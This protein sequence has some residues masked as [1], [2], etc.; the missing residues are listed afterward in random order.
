MYP[1]CI[2][3]HYKDRLSTSHCFPQIVPFGSMVQRCQGF[4]WWLSRINMFAILCLVMLSGAAFIPNSALSNQVCVAFLYIHLIWNKSETNAWKWKHVVICL[5]KPFT[6]KVTRVSLNVSLVAFW[7]LLMDHGVWFFDSW[8]AEVCCER[9]KTNPGFNNQNAGFNNQRDG[10]NNQGKMDST[11]NRFSLLVV[12]SDLDCK[13]RIIMR[14][15]WSSCDHHDIFFNTAPQSAEECSSLWRFYQVFSTTRLLWWRWVMNWDVLS[16]RYFNRILQTKSLRDDLSLHFKCVTSHHFT[17]GCSYHFRSLVMLSAHDH[18]FI[19][20][21]HLFLCVPNKDDDSF[22]TILMLLSS[23]FLWRCGVKVGEGCS[24]RQL[25]LWITSLPTWGYL[26]MI[27]WCFFV[28]HGAFCLLMT[29][30]F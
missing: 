27:G 11:T 20:V 15:W 13:L 7:A 22:A 24:C 17:N 4:K 1:G 25:C 9:K 19:E 8:T 18:S 23:T 26:R 6:S 30:S 5:L 29:W 14:I 3:S 21:L 16:G 2:L 10:F 12:E 28:V